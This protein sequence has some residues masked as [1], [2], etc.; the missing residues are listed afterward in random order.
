[1][2]GE[3]RVLP[4][5]SGEILME[6]VN[7][8]VIAVGNRAH[9]ALEAARF[10]EKDLGFRQLVFDPVWI[11]PLPEKDLADIAGR[12]SKLLIVEEG[13]LAGGFS[14]AVLEFLN[15]RG[16]LGGLTVKRLGLPDDFIE[17]GTQ[18]ELREMLGLRSSGIA[19]AITELAG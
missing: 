8:A 10:V 19:R 1:M 9:P 4:H 18:M 14:S 17:H 2:T 5:G 3:A 15:D 7:L 12:F 13:V 6:G 16:L 11:K